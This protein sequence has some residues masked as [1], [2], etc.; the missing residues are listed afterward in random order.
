MDELIAVLP[1]LPNPDVRA[2]A[3]LVAVCGYLRAGK[4]GQAARAS[5]QLVETAAGLTPHHRLHAA[6]QQIL[7]ATLTGRWEEVRARTAEAERAVDANLAARPPCLDERLHPP[8]LRC[9]CHACGR[10]GR[11]PP[12]G[13]KAYGIG[14][15]GIA[16]ITAG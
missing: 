12:A 7:L 10:R 6:C 8:E 4:L 9:R 3:L 16:G 1:E 5:A 15:E 14:M 11:G 13:G 2:T